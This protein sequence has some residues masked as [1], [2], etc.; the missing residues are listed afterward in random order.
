MKA[1]IAGRRFY[2]QDNSHNRIFEG[3]YGYR[4]LGADEVEAHRKNQH[5]GDDGKGRPSE[6]KLLMMQQRKR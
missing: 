1:E 2:A 4:I 6:Q 3:M 5:R